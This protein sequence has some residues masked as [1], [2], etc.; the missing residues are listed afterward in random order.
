MPQLSFINSLMK[1]K[2]L[3]LQFKL[4]ENYKLELERDVTIKRL[5]LQIEREKVKLLDLQIK[6]DKVK[7]AIIEKGHDHHS[8]DHND[9]LNNAVPKNKPEIIEKGHDHHSF[10]HNNYINNAIPKKKSAIVKL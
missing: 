9:Y 5:D 3:E 10:D 2:K 7:M 4:S 1:L 8:V 6:C